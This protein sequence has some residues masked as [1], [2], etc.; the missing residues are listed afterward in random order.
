MLKK[1]FTL[2]RSDLDEQHASAMEQLT[3]AM[4]FPMASG[5]QRNVKVFRPITGAALLAA[6]ATTAQEALAQSGCDTGPVHTDGINI[7]TDRAA[8]LPVGTSDH[9]ILPDFKVVDFKADSVT[10]S[11]G[12]TISDPS[13]SGGDGSGGPGG[14]PGG[15]RGGDPGRDGFGS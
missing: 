4:S 3:G 8:D 13:V 7:S 15:G 10:F 14:G 5:S 2:V 11:G 12:Q 1:I 9:R 6:A